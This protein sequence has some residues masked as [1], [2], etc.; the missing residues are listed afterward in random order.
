MIGY[1]DELAAAIQSRTVDDASLTEIANR[2][3]MEVVGP[4]PKGYA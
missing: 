2:Y 3:G 1:F 4:A